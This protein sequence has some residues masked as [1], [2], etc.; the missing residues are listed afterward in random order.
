SAS[1]SRSAAKDKDMMLI[2]EKSI[3]LPPWISQHLN[4]KGIGSLSYW[5][6]LSFRLFHALI[7][8]PKK[9]Q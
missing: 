3:S 7:D 6:I 9:S 1:R 4:L 8:E 2:G 5:P